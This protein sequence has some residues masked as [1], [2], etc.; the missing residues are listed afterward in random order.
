LAHGIN[1]PHARYS[2]HYRRDLGEQAGNDPNNAAYD[3]IGDMS[4]PAARADGMTPDGS[5]DAIVVGSGAA[6]LAAALTTARAG[7]RTI[8]LERTEAIGGTSAMSGGLVYA[9]GSRLAAGAGHELDRAGVAGY[10]EAVARRPIDQALLGAFLDAAPRMVEQLLDS[11]VALRLTGLVDYY[12]NVPGAT[13]GHVIAAQ[14]FDPASLGP[15][16]A[17]IRRSPYRDSEAVPWT[18]G[19][20]LVAQLVAAC[21]QAGVQ[22]RTACRVTRLLLEDDAIAGVVTDS[23]NGPAAVRARHVVLASG[24]YEFN[25]ALLREWVGAAIEGAWS[26][27]GNQGDGLAMARS[28]GAQLSAMGE[29]QW[30]ALLRLSDEELEGAP[31]FAD[32]SPARNLPGSIIVD[33]RGRRFGNEGT[34]FQDFGRSLAGDAP[35]RRPAWLITD[36]AFVEAYRQACF[37]DRPLGPPHWLTA[38]TPAGLASLISVAPDELV[39]TLHRF[40]EPA[41]KGIDPEFGRGE[42][43]IDREWGDTSQD[44]ARACL[45][46]VERGPFHATR[47]YAG[48]S[49]TT[50]GPKVDAAARVVDTTGAPIPGLY[51]AGNITA[52]L[53]GDAAPASGATLGPGMTFGYLAGC[54]AAASAR[55]SV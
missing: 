17:R 16:A 22:I 34:L 41:A 38:S 50:G 40:N 20:A 1:R 55:S 44:G 7:L 37:G 47:V 15:L 13:A 27:P 26:C 53:F 9:P 42:D 35:G 18:A 21:V 48:C 25:P 31:L 12:R 46:P 11:G 19:M 54:E 3:S 52:Q 45:A 8:V 30:Y 49:G 36:T 4:F 2:A 43:D 32:A 28:A 39:Q 14:P 29:V 10:L 51:A 33:S 6:G 23:R 24:G 5:F